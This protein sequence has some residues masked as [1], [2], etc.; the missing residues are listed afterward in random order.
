MAVTRTDP[1]I[2]ASDPRFV[3]TTGAD[4]QKTWRQYGW[5]PPSETRPPAPQET[6]Q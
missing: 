2:P 3:W 1:F 5:T 4:V 6:R